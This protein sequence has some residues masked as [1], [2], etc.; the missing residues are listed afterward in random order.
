MFEDVPL[1][2]R[3][4]TFKVKPKFPKEWRM[5]EERRQ[6][7]EETR[8]K[9]LLAD[10]AKAEQ[11]VLVD[12]SARIQQFLEKPAFEP[13]LATQRVTSPASRPARML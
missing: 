3:H 2:T 1:D 10:K 9:A 8:Q 4:H 11:G 6:F 12:G 7:I 5:T 13:Q